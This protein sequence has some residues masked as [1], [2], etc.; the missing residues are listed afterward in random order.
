MRIIVLDFQATITKY[1]GDK[2]EILEIGAFKL[3]ENLKIVS[4]FQSYIRP[5]CGA[6]RKSLII[7]GEVV[8]P[9]ESFIKER[10]IGRVIHLFEKW[11]FNDTNDYTI[12]TW[13]DSD[14]KMLVD[15]YSIKKFSIL[16]MKNH[17]DIQKY[18]SNYIESKRQI[19]LNDAYKIVSK[20]GIKLYKHNTLNNAYSTVVV[21]KYLMNNGV[22]FKYEKNPFKN[23]TCKTKFKCIKC[24]KT[25]ESNYFPSKRN[26]CFNCYTK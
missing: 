24:N 14:I 6:N 22:K 19:A 21:L 12:V 13:S 9:K 2:R 16:W 17:V 10:D 5:Y 15:N 3:D 25:K 8:I 26:V 23:I 18:F 11:L 7:D 20:E 1:K 4:K